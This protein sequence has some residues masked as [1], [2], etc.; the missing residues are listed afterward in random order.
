MLGRSED[1]GLRGAAGRLFEAA[2]PATLTFSSPRA[3]AFSVLGLQEYLDWFPGDRVIQST[4]NLLANRLL[5][6][7]ERSCSDRNRRPLPC[8]SSGELMFNA[9]QDAIARWQ[10]FGHEVSSGLEQY[11]FGC[12]ETI[13][14]FGSI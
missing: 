13:L 12:A 7:Y 5:D 14:L 8:Q 11:R 3:W 2:V 4:L 9:R 10:V 6:I 1:A